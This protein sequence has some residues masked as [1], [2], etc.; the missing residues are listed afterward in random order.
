MLHKYT[1]IYTFV[2]AF[3]FYDAS[4]NGQIF[5]ADNEKNINDFNRNYHSGRYSNVTALVRIL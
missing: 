5:L 3:V 1:S 2:S 4:E